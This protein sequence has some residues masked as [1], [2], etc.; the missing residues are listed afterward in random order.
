MRYIVEDSLRN[1]QAW[2]GGKDTLDALKEKGDCEEV[3][4]LIEE[5]FYGEEPP[6]DTDIN[7]YLWF[8]ADSIAESLGYRD[9]GAYMDGWSNED[10]ENAEDW[11]DGLDLEEQMELA[12][13]DEDDTQGWW[14]AKRDKEKVD[15]YYAENQV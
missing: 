10:L 5:M 8:E 15:I 2:S 12:E 7:D 11:W 1:F 4:Q 14:D 3:E 9:W 6:T 13:T